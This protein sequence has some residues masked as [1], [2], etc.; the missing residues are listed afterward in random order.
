M[1]DPT[2]VFQLLIAG[3]MAYGLWAGAKKSDR[4]LQ[5]WKDAAKSCGLQILA[6]SPPPKPQLKAR[7]GPIQVRIEGKERMSWIV[8]QV[9]ATPE[10]QHVTV[11]PRPMRQ[12]DPRAETGDPWFDRVFSVA[13]PMRLLLALLHAEARRWLIATCN[14]SSVQISDGELRAIV[15]HG[16][17][18]TFLPRLLDLSKRLAPSEIPRHLAETAL[19][20][21]EPGVRLQSLLVLVRELPD[22]PET[23]EALRKACSDP[24]PGIRLRA[25][26]QVGAEAHGVLLE[27]AESLEG[28][29]LSA[30]A[31][32]G[33]DQELPLERASAILGLALRRRRLLTA[34]A[35]L[36]TIGRRGAAAVDMLAKVLE[37]EH[38]DLALAAAQALAETGSRA[39]E[40]PLIQALQRED[41]DVRMAAIHALGRVGTAAAVLPLQ[42]TAERSGADVRRAARQAI[43]EIQSRLQGA[44]PGQL[45]LAGAEAGQ[46]SLAQ[47]GGELSLA[48]D[49]AGR[50]SLGDEGKPT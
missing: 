29:E 35:C 30:E 8:L 25:A 37:R 43:D 31:V 48:D 42:E 50:L 45:S 17:V 32:T 7:A 41:T 49:P 22:R 46:L 23:A 9:P 16:D 33:L 15:P 11:R 19:Q 1:I 26:M 36:E 18:S 44:T 38:G 40:T 2:L 14:A 10:F 13:G 21:P 27:L 3:S 28:D 24:V 6:T 12:R 47:E 4:R 39:A 20:D 34:R 5:A